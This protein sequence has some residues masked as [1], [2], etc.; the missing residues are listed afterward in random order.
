[1]IILPTVFAVEVLLSMVL[2]CCLDNSNTLGGGTEDPASRHDYSDYNVIPLKAE[3]ILIINL[4][5]TMVTAKLL[6]LLENI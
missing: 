6:V 4:E 2:D 1:M 5:R 3:R